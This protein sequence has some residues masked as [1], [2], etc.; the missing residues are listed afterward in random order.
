MLC[1]AAMSNRATGRFENCIGTQANA[2]NDRAADLE[3]FAARSYLRN[4]NAGVWPTYDV[5]R[6]S[7]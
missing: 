1:C 7:A 6:P 2:S 5:R 3:R 4:E